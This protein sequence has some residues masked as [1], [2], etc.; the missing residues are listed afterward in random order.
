MKFLFLSR[1]PKEIF[2]WNISV[3]ME[4]WLKISKFSAIDSLDFSRFVEN[5][6]VALEFSEIMSSH[7]LVL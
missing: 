1:A 4:G 2:R 6:Q 3:R 7:F 5:R